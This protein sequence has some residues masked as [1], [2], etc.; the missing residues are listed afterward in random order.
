MARPG[1]TSMKDV[2]RLSGV[3][4][5]TVSN[6][7]NSPD[8]VTE[9][10]RRRVL[11]AIDQLG[12]V[13]NESA[14]QLRAGDSRAIG[15]VVMDIA[16]PFFSDVIRGVDEVVAERGFSMHLGDSVQGV[17][18]EQ[19]HL[20]LFEEQRVRGALLAP[21]RDIGDWVDRLPVHGIPVVIVDHAADKASHCSVA[22][23][24]CQGGNLA[25]EHLLGRGHRRIAFVG[26]SSTLAQ[27]RD[28]RAG[29]DR[30][31]AHMGGADTTLLTVSTPRLDV[32][33]GA[34][35]ASQIAALSD[36]ERP[37]AVFAANDLLAIGLLQGFVALGLSVP[38][39][40]AI[41]GYDDIEFAAAAAVPISSIRQP[42]HEIGR[43]AAE[44]LFEEIRDAE[45]G[46]PHEHRSVSFSPTL[47]VR[48]STLRHPRSGGA[49]A[50]Q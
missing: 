20:A 17:E 19:V 12:W 47:V 30:A 2:A 9:Q 5:G 34:D 41:I 46:T 48:R 14:R 37:T 38:D 35:A 33:S 40:V 7:V 26:G 43:V 39:D 18:R 8:L 42:R 24:N 45:S 4:V 22:V 28:R 3:S 36:Q 29:A 32:R 44:L 1:E 31:I 49:P 21:V 27:V 25:V 15:M 11:D 6:V 50:E 10:T 13:R 16:N 23:D